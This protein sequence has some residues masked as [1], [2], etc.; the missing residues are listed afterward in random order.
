MLFRLLSIH[1]QIN[2]KSVQVGVEWVVP[3]DEQVA[4]EPGQTAHTVGGAWVKI[5]SVRCK[6]VEFV[7]K[8]P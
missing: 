8:E 1:P 4:Q 5:L 7:S 6:F 2:A 3:R